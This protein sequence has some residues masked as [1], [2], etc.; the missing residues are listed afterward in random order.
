MSVEQQRSNPADGIGLGIALVATGCYFILIALDVLPMPDG[1][2]GAPTFVI[3]LAGLAF[4]FA[5][6]SLAIRARAGARDSAE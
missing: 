4:V 5:G 1:G 6:V 2:A 3:V